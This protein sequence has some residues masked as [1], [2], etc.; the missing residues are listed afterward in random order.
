LKPPWDA[1]RFLA[2]LGTICGPIWTVRAA[3]K[4][5][6]AWSNAVTGDDYLEKIKFDPSVDVLS[7]L[8]GRDGV[9]AEFVYPSYSRS[10]IYWWRAV[11]R[12]HVIEHVSRSR[13]RPTF[14]PRT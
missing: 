2:A 1:I 7:D 10:G 9:P 11:V 5:L 13:T 14:T 12:S 6:Q 3:L 8:F 4:G